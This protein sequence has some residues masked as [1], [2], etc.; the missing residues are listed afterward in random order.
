MAAHEKNLFKG[1]DVLPTD[2]VVLHG[3]VSRIRTN[4]ESKNDPDQIIDDVLVMDKMGRAT[5]RDVFQGNRAIGKER[6]IQDAITTALTASRTAGDHKR[7]MELLRAANLFGLFQDTA[8]MKSIRLLSE[9]LPPTGYLAQ[10]RQVGFIARMFQE[11][12]LNSLELQYQ[13]EY[14][15]AEAQYHAAQAAA[16]AAP[17]PGPTPGAGAT[18]PN[19]GPTAGP[20][21]GSA[22]Q[23]GPTAPPPPPGP[24]A[25]TPNPN[26]APNV[27]VNT[28]P[29]TA[30]TAEELDPRLDTRAKSPE[31]A[32]AQVEAMEYWDQISPTLS[33]DDEA[34]FTLVRIEAIMDFIHTKIANHP[35][36]GNTDFGIQICAMLEALVPHINS[37]PQ[38][39]KNTII[40]LEDEGKNVNP[41]T[42]RELADLTRAIFI[43]AAIRN[44]TS[45][46]TRDQSRLI[47]KINRQLGFA[48]HD[49]YRNK[50]PDANPAL[51]DPISF[52]YRRA[53]L[54]WNEVDPLVN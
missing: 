10:L 31:F 29:K 22:P 35:G 20:A 40:F 30:W 50:N 38:V 41:Q 18:N 17:P 36:P 3:L 1:T 25:G 21:A 39:M 15:Q 45:R 6:F 49:D 46:P 9:V 54:W 34:D 23:P 13:A 11:L 47:K 27:N 53:N 33:I 7:V 43:P 4:Y 52:F 12:E 28:G 24:A 19:P 26:V 5:S 2:Q 37:D 8:R 48:I 14:A 32:A 42:V 51:T 44:R 16:A